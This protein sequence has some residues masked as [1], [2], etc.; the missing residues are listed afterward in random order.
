MYAIRSYY[1]RHGFGSSKNLSREK[2]LEYIPTVEPRGLRGGVIYYDGQ[3]D[4]ARLA[5]NMAQTA[6]EQGAT[7]INYMKVTGLVTEN[8]MIRGVTVQDAEDGETYTLRARGVINATGVWSDAIRRMDEPDAA[9]IITPSQGVH[10]VLDKSFL[11]GDTAI[12]VPHTDDGRVLFA[13]PWHDR[14]VVRNN[15]V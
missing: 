4:D 5:V 10:I 15:F 6:V 3:F 11:P 2:T 8:D 13:I 7:V 12:M 14:V 9:K 1:G